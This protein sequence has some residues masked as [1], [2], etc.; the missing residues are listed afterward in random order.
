MSTINKS[1]SKIIWS[2]FFLRLF[3]LILL[4][5]FGYGGLFLFN[6]NKNISK[7]TLNIQSSNTPNTLIT[8]TKSALN[9][10]KIKLKG[11]KGNRINI[12]LL[13]IGG[14]KHKGKYLTDTLAL[15]SINPKTYQS[16]I[17]SIPR[18]LYVKIP[19][20]T[21]HT[22]INAL[23]TYGLRNKKMSQKKSLALIEKSI[24]EIT[25]ENIHYYIIID[26]IG[27]KKII[28]ILGGVNVEVK[29]DIYDSHY[30]GPNYSYE[31]FKISKGFHH[32]DAETALKYARVRHTKGGDFGRAYRQQQIIA[33]AREKAL[34]L[35]ILAN[36]IKI[37]KLLNT[38]GEHLQTNITPA[39]IPNIIALLKNINI[40][41]TTNKV[42]D[43]WSKDSLLKSTHVPLGGV[44]AYVLLPKAKNY[45]QVHLLSK[46]I[47]NLKKLTEIKEKIK[48][49]NAII[50]LI[51]P[52][53]KSFLSF[54][55][56]MQEWGYTKIIYRNAK[57]QK[58]CLSKKDTITSNAQIKKLFTLNDLANKL[59]VDISY[60]NLNTS[61]LKN[62]LLSSKQKI[63]DI[64]LCL[65]SETV[66]YFS[67]PSKKVT[68]HSQIKKE[69]I[70]NKDGKALIN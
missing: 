52:N 3:F 1:G 4:L 24:E 60:K 34:S 23:Y 10:D 37:I 64:T 70:L 7:S 53:Y 55:K 36:P 51:T 56:V 45:S 49:E 15:A 67:Q 6:L 14:E 19:D 27:F 41:Q 54:K 38:L 33:S 26:F 22:K 39:E 69:I 12:L 63:P 9:K 31:T 18:D 40:Y 32:L 35:K 44:S 11:E 65:T 8:L 20:S 57:Y 46:N 30:P 17:L 62:N 68:S 61:T 48:K 47:F 43:A 29:D 59:N 2:G 16:S 25:G 5:I 66:N 50:E 28:N 13:G 42:L 21:F 58:K